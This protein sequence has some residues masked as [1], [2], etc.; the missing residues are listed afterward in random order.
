MITQSYHDL[1]K[2]I[3]ILETR[4]RNLEREHKF[5]YSQ[6][7][8]V[9]GRLAVPLDVCLKRME[10]ICDQVEFYATILDEKE[11][12]RKHM[13]KR[14]SEL[15]RIDYKVVYMRDIKGMTLMEIAV[16]LGYSYDW[17]K[18]ISMR[19]KRDYTNYTLYS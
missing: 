13:E 6:C 5:W 7:W 9:R 4:I 12:A 3:D 18:R 10:E 8:G 1:C 11:D 2:E 14:I 16:E 15:E 17:I 19:N